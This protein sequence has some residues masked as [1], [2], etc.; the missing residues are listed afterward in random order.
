VT[1]L[2]LDAAN[3]PEYV[4][5]AAAPAPGIVLPIL[6]RK[7]VVNRPA[8]H[9]PTPLNAPIL[10][11]RNATVTSF[12]HGPASRN[13]WTNAP[14]ARGAAAAIASAIAG[15][16]ASNALESLSPRFALFSAAMN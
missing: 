4:A 14:A 3:D 16:A 7:A 9:V 11:A 8:A 1:P 12:P 2:A 15:A 5:P 10:L 6:R 13:A